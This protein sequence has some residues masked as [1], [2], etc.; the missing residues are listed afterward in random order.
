MFIYQDPV[1]H[2]VNNAILW[3]NGYR[4]ERD[5]FSVWGRTPFEQ[6]GPV[7]KF[8]TRYWL[9]TELGVVGC[10]WK[11][12]T[13]CCLPSLLRHAP[14]PANYSVSVCQFFFFFHE[15]CATL[16]SWY[17]IMDLFHLAHAI[18]YLKGI[19]CNINNAEGVLW[20][21]QMC[22]CFCCHGPC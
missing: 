19:N 8:T 15:L 6:P 5:L 12:R 10:E 2:R 17:P 20:G 4:Q 9:V 18:F 21:I 14:V 3:I 11:K 7:W 1:F 16:F 13:L 22:E